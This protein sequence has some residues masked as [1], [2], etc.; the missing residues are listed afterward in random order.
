MNT[1]SINKFKSGLYQWQPRQSSIVIDITSEV[2]VSC[3]HWIVLIVPKCIK[4]SLMMII[5][6]I[7][8]QFK[9]WSSLYT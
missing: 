6:N 3:M 5:F 8:T 7:F 1:N 2:S 4:C 9:I